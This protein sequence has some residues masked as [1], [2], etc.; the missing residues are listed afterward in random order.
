M[1]QQSS[2]ERLS[3]R[4]WSKLTENEK[5]IY[6]PCL[7]WLH[8]RELADKVK[9]DFLKRFSTMIWNNKE[10]NEKNKSFEKILN[11]KDDKIKSLQSHVVNCESQY[12]T[13]GFLIEELTFKYEEILKDYNCKAANITKEQLGNEIDITN[14]TALENFKERMD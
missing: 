10:N 4:L 11:E 14:I 8:Q 3:N 6:G 1:S 2:W 9:I 5:G 12:N 13:L 7:E